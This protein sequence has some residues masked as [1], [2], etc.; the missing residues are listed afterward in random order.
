M[1]RESGRDR[2]YT[3]LGTGNFNEDTA[4][5]FADHML[6]TYD[7]EIGDDAVEIFRFFRQSYQKPRLKHLNI[8]P[9]DL[10]GFLRDK[11]EREIAHQ[12]AGRPSG[13]SVK[14]NN[15]SDPATN[16]LFHQASGAG[17]PVRLIV[18][19]MYSLVVEDGGPIEAISIVD[20]YLEHSRM[21][22]FTNGG[23]PEVYLSSADFMPRN[24]DTRV[25]TQL[26][27]YFDIPWSDNTTARLLDRNLTNGYRVAKKGGKKVRAQFAIEDYLRGTTES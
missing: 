9:F 6:F 12:A 7:Q 1:R 3:V 11:V 24:F 20:K 18:R 17:V 4:S 22:I 27:D 19:S 16:A 26:I 13:I 23:E 25:E 14:L 21:L 8:A 10:R 5:I 2:S 15:F